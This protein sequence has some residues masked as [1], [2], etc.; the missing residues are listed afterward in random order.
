MINSDLAAAPVTLPADEGVAAAT[1]LRVRQAIYSHDRLTPSDMD[2]VFDVAR[3]PGSEQCAEWTS[4]FSEALTDYVVH[5][6]VPEDYIP[7]DKADWLVAKLKAGGG[8]SSRAEF[9]MLIDATA[10]AFQC[11]CRPSHC[12]RSQPQSAKADALHFEKWLDEKESL[13]GFWSRMLHRAPRAPSFNVL[14]SPGEAVEVDLAKREA[15]ELALRNESEKITNDEAAWVIAHLGREGELTS[16]EKRLLHFIGA[17]SPS[18][19]PSLQA[20]IDRTNAG[21]MPVGRS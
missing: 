6:N 2:L 15:Q 3:T 16:A 12:A 20:L 19:A 7:Q 13:A 8:I 17:E 10:L 11:R 14:R 4:L 9:A 18:I 21:A 5:Q 1:V